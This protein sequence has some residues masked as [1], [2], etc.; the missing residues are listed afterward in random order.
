MNIIRKPSYVQTKKQIQRNR[1][2]LIGTLILYMTQMR[3]IR[4]LQQ[5]NKLNPIKFM[6][7]YIH[8]PTALVVIQQSFYVVYYIHTLCQPVCILICACRCP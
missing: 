5:S 2:K 3:Y 7:H 8:N 1:I 6:Q 4:Y